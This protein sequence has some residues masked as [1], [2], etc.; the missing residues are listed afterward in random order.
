MILAVPAFIRESGRKEWQFALRTF[1]AGML[2]LYL[3]LLLGLD[4][5]QWALM[6]VYIVAQPLGGMVI[7]KGLSRLVGTVLGAVMALLLVGGFAQQPLLFFIAIGAWLALCTYLANLLRNFRSYA[8]VL[9]GYTALIIGLPALSQPDQMFTVAVARVTEIGLGILCASAASVLVWPRSAATAYLHRCRQQLRDLIALVADTA[10]GRADNRTLQQRRRELIASGMALEALRENALF[11][12]QQLR[13]RAGLCRRLGHEMLALISSV[14]PLGAYV[15]RYASVHQQDRLDELLRGMSELDGELDPESLRVCLSGLH[16]QARDLARGL[17]KETVGDNEQ[18]FHALQL[19]LEHCGELCDR[20]RSSVVLYA[21]LSDQAL[22]QSWRSG[23]SRLHLD[24][25]QALRSAGRT[26]I[27][28]AAAL[29]LWFWSAAPSDQGTLMVIQTGVVCALFS[30]RD[31]PLKAVSGFLKGASLA[32]ILATLYRLVL[33][34]GTEGFA[35]LVLWLAPVYLLAGLAM[36]QLPSMAMG[37]ATVIFFPILL[38]LGPQQDFSAL[39]LF[40]NVLGLAMGLLLPVLAF[41]LIWPGDDAATAR[42]RLCRDLCRTLGRWPMSRRRPRHE[43]ETV[44]YDRIART[45]PRLSPESAKDG[46]LLHG[47]MAAVT[48]GLGLLF[49]DAL[50]RRGVPDPIRFTLTRLIRDT[51]RVLRDGDEARWRQ[52]SADTERALR[53]C[54]QAYNKAEGEGERRRLVRAVVRLRMQI[55]MIGN[56]GGFFLAG[57]GAGRWRGLEIAHAV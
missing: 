18:R 27:A 35:A 44:L 55:N 15:N 51:Q 22:T 32:V 45:L 41:L 48:L 24:H 50:C 11:D 21:M 49:L 47:A 29:S 3:A 33:L 31:D 17:R 26:A 10:G 53:Q 46:E 39:P 30:T 9:S 19:A 37:T 14:G 52:L 36:T 1:A 56:Y 57:S 23:T 20:L 25:G 42:T 13:R 28:I 8:F 6:T 5:P 38:D 7:A 54:Q 34:P 40:N 4:Q 2:A 43:M 12:S 16:D